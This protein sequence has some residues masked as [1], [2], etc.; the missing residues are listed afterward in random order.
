MIGFHY[1]HMGPLLLKQKFKCPNHKV[2]L[3]C[4]VDLGVYLDVSLDLPFE[5][6]PLL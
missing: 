1:L 6:L 5:S 3:K 2:T 4:I